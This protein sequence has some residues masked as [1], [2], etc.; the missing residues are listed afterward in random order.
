MRVS[1]QFKVCKAASTF[2]FDC[3][4]C[5]KR[6]RKRTFR[7]EYTVN[8]FNT[9]DDGAIR[10]AKEVFEQ[11]KGGVVRMI[12]RFKREP[13]CA[14]CEDALSLEERRSLFTRRILGKD[15]DG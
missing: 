4:S 1:Y 9:K 10:D 14:A 2:T 6:R 13:L 8:P 12:D 3:P 11:A 5:G 15:H 7:A